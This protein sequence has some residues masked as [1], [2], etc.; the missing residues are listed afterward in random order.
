MLGLVR[1]LPAFGW[2]PIVVAPPQIPWEPVDESLL[3]QVPPQTPVERVPFAAGF[4]GKF[5][6]YFAPESHWLLKARAAINRLMREHRIDAVI[7]SSPPGCVHWL[8]LWL[9]KRGMP[10]VADFRDPWIA[11]RSFA[12]WTLH[13]RYERWL[14]AKV[15]R[16]ATRLI[17]NT[18]LN[19]RGWE[20][21]FPEAADKITVITNGF[22]PERFPAQP[23]HIVGAPPTM[24]HAGELYWGRDPRG[25]LDALQSFR[26]GLVVDFL[27]R[28]S[29]LDFDFAAEIAKRNLGD[30]VRTPGMVPYA[31]ALDRMMRADILL[32]VQTP[33]LKLGVPAKLY[34]YLG[35]GRPILALAEPD[36]DIGWVLRESKVLHRIA[37]PLDVTAIRQALVE[38]MDDV[39]AGRP[40]APDRDAIQQF[41]RVSMAQRFAECLDQCVPASATVPT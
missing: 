22:D 21:A 39:H 40:A 9:A 28:T 24:L 18:P 1:H 12:H 34:E 19:Q 3:A 2:Q 16:R 36:G 6:R 27:G 17:A 25:L 23:P 7:T 32:L 29:G 41:T 15:M 20:S 13:M 35:A 11:N 31:Q 30:I 5:A 14:E 8:G 4:F 37:A 10:W 33:G 38:L 26:T